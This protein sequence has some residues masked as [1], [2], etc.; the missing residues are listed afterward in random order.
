M[1]YFEELLHIIVLLLR[2]FIITRG[3]STVDLKNKSKHLIAACSPSITPPLPNN[4]L[5][6]CGFRVYGTNLRQFSHIR[7]TDYTTTMVRFIITIYVDTCHNDKIAQ[8]AI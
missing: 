5:P 1:A 8:Y 7:T 4:P 6:S 3:R 2:R